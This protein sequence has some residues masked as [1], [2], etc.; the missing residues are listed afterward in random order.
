MTG[1]IEFNCWTRFEPH[2]FACRQRVTRCPWTPAN[3]SFGAAKYSSRPAILHHIPVSASQKQ[4]DRQ[5]SYT[6]ALWNADRKFCNPQRVPTFWGSKSNDRPRGKQ[7]LGGPIQLFQLVGPGQWRWKAN[8]PE[9]AR[10]EFSSKH[11][12]YFSDR[13]TIHSEVSTEFSVLSTTVGS[14]QAGVVLRKPVLWCSNAFVRVG[15]QTN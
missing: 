2:L 15:G 13:A 11:Y 1:V 14:L 4:D 6:P 8:H 9:T 7:T 3:G 10:D 5:R 12:L